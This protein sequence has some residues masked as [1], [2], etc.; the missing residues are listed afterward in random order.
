MNPE[1]L[2]S[3][4]FYVGKQSVTSDCITA[5]VR[6]KR[7]DTTAVF[8]RIKLHVTIVALLT[9]W[10]V[11]HANRLIIDRQVLSVIAGFLG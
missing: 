10:I 5:T 9:N 1:S 3:N 2:R 7:A 4:A 8:D 11:S 6:L